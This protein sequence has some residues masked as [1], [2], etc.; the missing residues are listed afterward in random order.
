MCG[1]HED[2][3]ACQ[4]AAGLLVVFERAQCGVDD[5]G[6]LLLGGRVCPAMRRQ[7]RRVEEE[8][9][10]RHVDFNELLLQK[11]KVFLQTHRKGKVDI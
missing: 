3:Q 10:R 5:S 11:V 7:R 1:V 6:S 2:L 9:D 8:I 4:R